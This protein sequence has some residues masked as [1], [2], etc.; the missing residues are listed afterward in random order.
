MQAAT[1]LYHDVVPHGQLESSGFNGPVANRYKLTIDQFESHLLAVAVSP[2]VALSTARAVLKNP[3]GR[4]CPCLFSFDDGGISFLTEIADRLEAFN[5]RGHFFITTDYL[6]Q[7]GFLSPE[8]VLELH[9]RGHIIGTHSCSHPPRIDQLSDAEL[10][11][12]WTGSTERLSDLLHAPIWCGSVP[13]GFFSERVAAAAERAGLKLLF[14]S[15][16]DCRWRAFGSMTIAG[17]LP[18]VRHTTAESVV[19]LASAN[20]LT[21]WRHQ[22]VWKSKQLAKSITGRWYRQVAEWWFRNSLEPQAVR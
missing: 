6:G 20:P 14:N 8:Q 10:L 9:Q 5:W 4:Q 12:E 19:K 17:R 2:N 18:I 22:F 3:V 13:G 1:L 16:P 21:L 15:E 7:P 11:A